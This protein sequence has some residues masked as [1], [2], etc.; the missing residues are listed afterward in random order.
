MLSDVLVFWRK[1]I[2]PQTHATELHGH[3]GLYV[4]EDPRAFHVF[5]GNQG[6]QAC[7]KR[8]ARGRL[9]AARRCPWRVGQPENV[10]RILLSSFG[11]LSTSEA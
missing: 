5:G 10:R 11:A 9:V 8:I 1:V 7:I 2:N 3:T 4:G 6:D